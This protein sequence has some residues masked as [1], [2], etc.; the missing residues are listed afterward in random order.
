MSA[1]N[2]GGGARHFLDLLDV[3]A[4]TL[5]G[6][7]DASA[8]MKIRARAGPQRRAASGWKARPWR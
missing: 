6:I 7:L 1:L 3:P 8:S 2:G 4:P 5:R